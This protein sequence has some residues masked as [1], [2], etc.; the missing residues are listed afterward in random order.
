[1]YVTG[2]IYK[3]VREPIKT[4]DRVVIVGGPDNGKTGTVTETRLPKWVDPAVC[5]I[6]KLPYVKLDGT[7]T[8]VLFPVYQVYKIQPGKE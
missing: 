5:Y 7:E 1:M 4:G 2:Q 3:P 6:E 8:P